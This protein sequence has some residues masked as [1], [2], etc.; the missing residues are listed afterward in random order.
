MWRFNRQSTTGPGVVDNLPSQRDSIAAAATGGATGATANVI[1]RRKVLVVDDNVDSASSLAMLL[2]LMGHEVHVANDGP[3]ALESVAI[4]QPEIM[5]LDIGLPS[6]D[7]YEVASRLRRDA[8]AKEIFL[9]AL[10]GYGTTRDVARS[11]EVGFDMHVVKP[12]DIAQLNQLLLK[13]FSP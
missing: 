10:S 4:A 9:V 11:N 8:A 6:M 5:F 3:Q 1:G 2:E 12:I 7:G 13:R